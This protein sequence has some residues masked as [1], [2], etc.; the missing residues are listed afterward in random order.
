M[1]KPMNLFAEQIDYIAAVTRTLNLDNP[2]RDVYDGMGH[3]DAIRRALDDGDPTTPC[4]RG[5]CALGD[6]HTGDCRM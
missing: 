6:G 4:G 5:P 1:T 2:P 3:V